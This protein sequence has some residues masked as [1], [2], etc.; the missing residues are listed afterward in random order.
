M[1]RVFQAFADQLVA[2]NSPHHFRQG[3]ADATAALNL[4]CFAYLALPR[5]K[6]TKPLLISNYPLAWTSHYIKNHYE[7]FDPVITQTLRDSQPFQWG[8]DLERPQSTATGRALFEEAAAFGIRYG[9]TIPI[10]DSAGAVAAVTFATDERRSTFERV[11]H[12]QSDVLQLMAMCFHAHVRRK[13]IQP[14]DQVCGVHL[15]TREIECLRW[16]AEGKSAWETGRIVGISHHTVAFHLENAKA[17]LGVRSTIQAIA[18]LSLH[19]H[20]S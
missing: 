19:S 18:K 9:F 7:R 13:L 5:G 6:R 12:T 14:A 17:K 20:G 3:M 10:H 2:S 1:R 15:S 11:I 16:A 8:D 4:C